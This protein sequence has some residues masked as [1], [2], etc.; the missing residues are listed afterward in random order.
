MFQSVIFIFIFRTLL[1]T[2]MAR[3]IFLFNNVQLKYTMCVI[4]FKI[5]K[6]YIQ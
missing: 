5:F 3:K 6:Y 2:L 4:F 1:L